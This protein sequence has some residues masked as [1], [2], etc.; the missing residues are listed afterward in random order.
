ML[1]S[2]ASSTSC[3]GPSSTLT[4]TRWMP[5]FWAHATPPTRTCRGANVWNDFGTSMREEILIGASA[6]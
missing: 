6:E 2:S 3:Q 5:V 1:S 4:S